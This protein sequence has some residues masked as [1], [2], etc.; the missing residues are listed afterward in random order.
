MGF[1][2]SIL[3]FANIINFLFKR[4]YGYTYYTVLGFV[5]GSIISIAPPLDISMEFLFGFL[6]CLVGGIA[7]YKL[8]NLGAV[9]QESGDIC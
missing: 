7:S 6:L 8:S 4:I 2:L 1:G 3:L 5:L 9:S